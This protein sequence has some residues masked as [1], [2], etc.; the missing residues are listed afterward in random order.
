MFAY[1][2]V[3]YEVWRGNVQGTR[4]ALLLARGLGMSKETA[5]EA[6]WY[7]A[8]FFGGLGTVAAVAEPVE[9][10]LASW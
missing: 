6:I 10:A 5:V 4:D 7:G 1:L 2:L 3:H 8:S 9:E